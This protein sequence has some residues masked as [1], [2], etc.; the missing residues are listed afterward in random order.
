MAPASKV[1]RVL[2]LSNSTQPDRG[3]LD[4]AADAVVRHLRGA[5]SLLFVPF[6]LHDRAS[7]AAKARD[8]FAALG[9]KVESLHDAR[10]PVAAVARAESLFI[11]GGNTFRLLDA[12]Q[13]ARLLDP[14]RARV[15]AGMPYLGA[16]A[17][18]NVACRTI[19][20][21]ND[22]PIVQPESFAALALLPF[23]LN[24]HYLDPDPSSKH[25]GET[26][27]QRLRE[28][29]EM[30]ATPVV[31]LREGGWLDVD[32]DRMTLG[33]LGTVRLFRRGAPA[34]E[35]QVGA[36]LSFLLQPESAAS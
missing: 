17:G 22:M 36:D 13:S 31:G 5:R 2:L 4:H 24:P 29:H 35:H 3:Y 28:F 20:T 19:Q 23:N 14:I 25:M 10:D 8:R 27:E 18:S 12:L 33:G 16:S 30:N 11:G 34:T 9:V 7:Y 21:T 6:A 1:R 26:R 32:G 15:A